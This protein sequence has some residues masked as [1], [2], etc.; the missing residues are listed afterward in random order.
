MRK[1]LAVAFLL[2]MAGPLWA[3]DKAAPVPASKTVAGDEDD[4]RDRL[5]ERFTSQGRGISFRPPLGGVQTKRTP[6]AAEI[7]RYSAADEKWSLNVS[8]LNFDK[9]AK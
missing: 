5:G 9:P 7:V 6:I 8:M 4:A 3:A 1:F 2:L